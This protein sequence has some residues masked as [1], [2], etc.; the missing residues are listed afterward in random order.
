[1]I[2]LLIAFLCLTPCAVFAQTQPCSVDGLS[3][4]NPTD[5]E[6]AFYQAIQV[7]P[8]GEPLATAE[9][10]A[11]TKENLYVKAAPSLDE[12]YTDYYG[13]LVLAV[14]QLGDPRTIQPL[15]DV[16]DSGS[17]AIYALAGFGAAALD[18]VSAKSFSSDDTVRNAVILTANLMLQPG[19]S[20]LVSDDIAKTKLQNIYIRGQ[21]DAD[22]A[23][24]KIAQQGAS[25]LSGFANPYDLNHDGIIS[26]SDVQLVGRAINTVPLTSS[27]PRDVNK[28]GKIDALDA[29][30]LTNLCTFQHCS[31]QP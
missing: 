2:R 19:Y 10:N 14:S 3:S 18:A 6:A 21:K 11:L 20:A 24:R 29:R 15:A 5:R 17:I 28:D 26:L 31:D 4:D 12:S 8:D 13:S 27:D 1:M 30:L 7:C 25:L 16:I 22:A 9:I 23:V